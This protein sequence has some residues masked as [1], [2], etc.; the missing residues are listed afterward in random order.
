MQIISCFSWLQGEKNTVRIQ[1]GTTEQ[2]LDQVC[3]IVVT[4]FPQCRVVWPSVF[5]L[6]P[7]LT[8]WTKL[9]ERACAQEQPPTMP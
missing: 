9:G 7:F 3:L 8:S 6:N 1:L 4:S 2:N 5:L